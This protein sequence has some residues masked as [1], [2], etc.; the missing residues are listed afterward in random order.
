[1]AINPINHRGD[2]LPLRLAAVRYLNTAPLIEGL[3]NLR[4][5]AL[6]TAAPSHI[7]GLLTAG[8]ADL[9]LVSIV[10]ALRE[11]GPAGKGLAIVP[12][13]MIGCDGPTLTV[14]V[15]SAVPIDQI[16]TL[17]ADTDSHTSVT[18]ARVLLRRITGREV[19]TIDFDARERIAITRG[20]R[21]DQSE[22][23]T[24]VLLIGDKVVTDSPPAVRYPYQLDLG[25]AW[26]AWTGLPFVYAA[27]MCRAEEADSEKIRLAAALL[28]R[29]LRH[30]LTRLDWIVAHK[31]PEHRWPIDLAQTY[32]RELLR[33]QLGP[34]ERAG[35]ARFFEEAGALGLVARRAPVWADLPGGKTGG[36]T[37]A[38]PRARGSQS[39]GAAQHALT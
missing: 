26:K 3:Q 39:I 23:P 37:D 4:S 11:P 6:T 12:V 27:W 30:N 13:G 34:R 5:I 16:R 22:W 8:E 10:D 28:D 7:A 24:T 17:H 29:Q 35:A 14:R 20:A 31:A 36:A 9:G 25:E 2:D 33:Y 18:L 1:M 21:S 15:F 38:D 19:E 32:I